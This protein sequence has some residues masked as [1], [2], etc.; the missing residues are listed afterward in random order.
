M[1]TGYWFSAPAAQLLGF[2]G[3][4]RRIFSTDDLEPRDRYD[5]WHEV[6]C[7]YVIPHDS[8]PDCPQAFAASLDAAELADLSLVSF[9][10]G[11]MS[12]RH[13]KHHLDETADELILVRQTRG[14]MVIRQGDRSVSLEPGEMTLVE[15]RV[16]YDARLAAGTSLLVT[17][18]PRRNM[19]ERVGRIDQFIARK[20]T[21]DFGQT[22]L[23]SD[24]L[25]VLP[26]HTEAL[27]ATAAQVSDQLLD[28]LAAGLW[29]LGGDEIARVTSSRALLR[30]QLRAVIERSVEDH[31]IDAKGIAKSVGIGLRY[32]NAI[33]SE[34]DTSVGR[35][36]QARRLEHCRR[37]LANPLK[38]HRSISDIAYSLGFTDMTHFGRRFR[39]A[40]GMLPSDYRRL[41]RDA[42]CSVNS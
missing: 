19:I 30:M 32:A 23:L 41:Q 31:T 4:M 28:L 33:L 34:D 10:A 29:K 12:C 9:D 1:T 39:Q 8:V 6:I 15:P 24:F 16:P 37:A 7:K 17:K 42:R 21:A 38:M 22:G 35:L 13:E 36:L 25:R 18:F 2:K 14:H 11:S 27:S 40:F 26:A 3:I 20:L 5:C